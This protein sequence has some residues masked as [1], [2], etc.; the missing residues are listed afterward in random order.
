[1]AIVAIASTHDD[2][3]LDF[4]ERSLKFEKSGVLRHT[5][6]AVLFDAGRIGFG[7]SLN[8]N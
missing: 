7:Q 1:M 6:A 4:L 5:L 8:S 2:W 3:A